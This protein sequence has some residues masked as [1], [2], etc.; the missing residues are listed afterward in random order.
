MPKNPDNP[1]T[2]ADLPRGWRWTTL[3][4]VVELHDDLREPVNAD[5]RADRRGPYPYYG[6]TGQVGWIDDFRM[7]GEYVLLGEDGAPFFDQAKPKAYIVTGKCWVNNHA[8]VLRGM[9]GRL[10]NRFLLYALNGV[11]YHGFANG[12]TRLKLTQA[13]M[14]RIPLHV[15]PV[16]MQEAIAAKLDELFT[17]LDAGVAALQ[18]ARANLKRYRAAV[19]KAAVEGRLTAEWRNEHPPAESA[20]DLLKRILAERRQTWEADQL[21]KFA[22]SGKTPPKGWQAKYSTPSAPDMSS[23][24]ALPEGWCWASFPQLD[25]GTKNAMKAGPFGSALKKSVYTSNGFKIYGQEQ[26]IRGDP[27]YG[28][29]YIAREL[30][31]RLQSCEVKPGDI[32]ISLVG[33]AGKVLILPSDAKE[34]I[35]NPRLVK[36]SLN[37]A[38][39][40]ATYVKLL[41]ESPSVRAYFKQEA[42]GGTMEILNLGTFK[43]MPV[44][45]PSLAEQQ[46]IVAEVERRLSVADEVEAQIDTNLKRAA[47]LRQAVLKRAFAGGLT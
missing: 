37:A 45:L 36:F 22:A 13:A 24:P 6:A 5:A 25:N 23:L 14:K 38:A 43:A 3:E 1:T 39:V 27:Y 15:P 42:H 31:E 40:D 8:H 35:I 41:I 19:L 18:R 30:F 20:A 7:D 10:T 2:V 29:Y 26:V 11:D 47:R 32:L 33:T 21:A 44:P 46:Q 12:T 28:D 17:D 16:P 9:P 34:G 4:H